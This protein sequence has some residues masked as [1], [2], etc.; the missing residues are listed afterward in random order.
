MVGMYYY[1]HT[2]LREKC[3]F[4]PITLCCKYKAVRKPKIIAILMLICYHMIGT[5]GSLVDMNWTLG[6]RTANGS[7]PTRERSASTSTISSQLPVIYISFQLR[8]SNSYDAH[9]YLRVRVFSLHSRRGQ[10]A[11]SRLLCSTTFT[12]R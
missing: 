3:G 8:K 6:C 5:N 7:R 2:G 12:D 9:S 1:F 4:Q 10:A 11:L